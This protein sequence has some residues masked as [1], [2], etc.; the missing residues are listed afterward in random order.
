MKEL[1]ERFWSKVKKSD[2][3]WEWQGATY[4]NGYGAFR[5]STKLNSVAHRTAYKISKGDPGNLLVCHTCDN[6]L[7]VRPDHLFL[8]TQL[9]N[10]QDMIKKGRQALGKELN[11]PSQIGE[12]NFAAKLTWDKVSLIRKLYNEGSKQADLMRQFEVS[13]NLIWLIVHNK[14]WIK[15]EE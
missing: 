13:R 6:R 10:M 9:D 4:R 8:G 3:C 7:C 14:I 2:N 12:L 5:E 11:H 1:A 15:R